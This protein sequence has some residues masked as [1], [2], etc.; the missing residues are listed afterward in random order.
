MVMLDVIAAARAILMN[1]LM[2]EPPFELDA[3]K[4]RKARFEI[5]RESWECDGKRI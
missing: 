1:F 3:D 2:R 4:V 5:L